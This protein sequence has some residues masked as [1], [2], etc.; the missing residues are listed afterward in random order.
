MIAEESEAC[1]KLLLPY[2]KQLLS[3]H[4]TDVIAAWYLFDH[5]AR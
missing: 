5:V 4:Q 2:I 3:S 1:L